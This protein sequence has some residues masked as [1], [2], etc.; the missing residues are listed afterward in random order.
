MLLFI[1]VVIMMLVFVISVGK[2]KADI[3]ILMSVCLKTPRNLEVDCLSMHIIFQRP[4]W[5]GPNMYL[6]TE[7][8]AISM[9]VS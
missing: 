9:L 3:L 7:N 2:K 4:K 8:F 1:D 6:S 5:I